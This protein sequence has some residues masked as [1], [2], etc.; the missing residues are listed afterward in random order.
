MYQDAIIHSDFNWFTGICTHHHYQIF[1]VVVRLLTVLASDTSNIFWFRFG[2]YFIVKN[3]IVDNNIV[4]ILIV[5]FM[6]IICLVLTHKKY[7]N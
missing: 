1:K 3:M 2:L 6:L 7:L 5:T 4:T